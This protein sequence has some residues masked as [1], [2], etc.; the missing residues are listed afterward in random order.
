MARVASETQSLNYGNELLTTSNQ[1]QR[2]F[3]W[4]KISNGKNFRIIEKSG[5]NLVI[6]FVA[7]VL[8]VECFCVQT[9]NCRYWT[10]LDRMLAYRIME[11]IYE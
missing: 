2:A 6:G 11:N 8:N 5:T 7:M 3:E 10:T 9:K 4:C 1:Y